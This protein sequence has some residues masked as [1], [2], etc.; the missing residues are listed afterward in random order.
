LPPFPRHVAVTRDLEDTKFAATFYFTGSRIEDSAIRVFRDGSLDRFNAKYL[1]IFDDDSTQI[2]FNTPSH[3]D[4]L[5][6]RSLQLEARNYLKHYPIGNDTSEWPEWGGLWAKWLTHSALNGRL[7]EALKHVGAIRFQEIEPRR[8]IDPLVEYV[9]GVF[10]LLGTASR[11]YEYILNREVAIARYLLAM[12]PKNPIENGDTEIARSLTKLLNDTLLRQT[13]PLRLEE[14]LKALDPMKLTTGKGRE[15]VLTP[16]GILHVF[17]QFFFEFDNFLGPAVEH[18][19]LAPGATIE[20]VEVSTR[21]TLVEETLERSLER[22][23]STETDTTSED[24][25]ADALKVENQR[26]TKQGASVSAGASVLVAHGET[27]ASMSVEETQ[28]V[29]R[30][31]NHR[32]KRQQSTKLASEIRSNVRSMF[33]TLT[34]TT[35]MRSKRHVIENKIGPDGGAPVLVNYEL[36]RKMRQVGV[37][38]QDVGTQLC[39]QIFVDDPGR[40]L[41]I[42]QLV[43]LAAKSDLSKLADEALKQL[44]ASATETLSL[45][46]PVPKPGER[47]GMGPIAAS[48]F[49]GLMAGGVPGVAAGVAVYEVLESLFGDDDDEERPVYAI[50]GKS[51][52]RQ[53]YRITLPPGFEIAPAAEQDNTDPQFVLSNSA[54]LGDVPIRHM[55][56]GKG[57]HYRAQIAGAADGRLLLVVDKGEVTSSEVLEFQV[58][59]TIRPTSEVSAAVKAENAQIAKENAERTAERARKLKEDFVNGVRDRVRLASGIRKRPAED[60]REE[61]RTV[62]YRALL[63]RLMRDAWSLSADRKVA[64]LRSEFIRSIFDV[65][66]MFYAVAPEWWQPRRRSGQQVGAEIRSTNDDGTT[67]MS[68]T[69]LKVLN[70]SKKIS[71]RLLGRA[72]RSSMGTLGADELVGWGGESRSENYLI[73]EDSNPAR[74]GASLGWLLQLDGDNLRN[75]FLNAP[76][77]K[78]VIPIRPGR[79]RDALE[80]LEQGEVEGG[81]GLDEVYLGDDADRFRNRLAAKGEDRVPTIREVLYMVADDVASKARASLEPIRGAGPDGKGGTRE[82]DYLLPERVFEFGFDPLKG[83]F[84]ARAEE[85]QIFDVMDQWVEVLPTDQIVAVKVDYDSKTGRML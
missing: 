40:E 19:W 6:V 75:A 52:L 64:H 76:W 45:L 61:E 47:S 12:S 27:S 28:R 85:G 15:G 80:W 16:I 78:A 41:G 13:P 77:V 38:T 22:A 11:A 3:V 8:P 25:F 83:G 49:L 29:A 65:D 58:R 82:A 57:L 35:D 32:T 4:G 68:N 21:R 50:G 18:I 62:I 59:M 73:T 71:E 79:E 37:Q 63:A 31:D 24:E 70:G 10:A 53:E 44:P 84:R 7:E 69:S 20:L 60:Q 5:L 66:K 1:D 26:D 54:T 51:V 23:L 55:A 43:H 67:R 56:N 39:W 17:R 42:G 36:R 48:G 46:L 74:L 34:E 9:S 72:K 30:E 81:D 2:R 14:T 33:R